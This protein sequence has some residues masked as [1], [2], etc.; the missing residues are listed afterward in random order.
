MQLHG[1]GMNHTPLDV[2]DKL[3]CVAT[4]REDAL[5]LTFTHRNKAITLRERIVIA[6]LISR[7]LGHRHHM[8]DIARADFQDLEMPK[9]TVL[10]GW[11]ASYSL[12]SSYPNAVIRVARYLLGHTA[13]EEEATIDWAAVRSQFPQL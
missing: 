11:L 8:L 12:V 6:I 5:D 4:L 3:V 10:V 1:G 9:F 13:Q 2:P 7:E